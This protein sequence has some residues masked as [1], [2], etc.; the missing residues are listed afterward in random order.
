MIGCST[1][2]QVTTTSNNTH[3]P[4]TQ[5]TLWIQ[6]AAEYNALTSLVYRTASSKI[7]L[8]LA[9]SYW[10]AALEQEEPYFKLPPA[11]ILD[12]DETVLDNSPFQARMIRQGS[13]FNPEAWTKWV[14]EAQAE[15][16]LGA[17]EFTKYAANKGITVFYVTNRERRVEGATRTN[18]IR[19]GFPVADS[20]DVLLTKNEREAWTSDKTARREYVAKN[21]R[22]LMLLGDDLNDFVSTRNTGKQERDQLVESNLQKWGQQWF[23]LPNPTYGSWEQTLS[24]PEDSLSE[25]E[26]IRMIEAQ[27]NT[28]NNP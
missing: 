13:E 17:L 10:T 5:A 11:V 1:S 28:K 4:T 7:D 15:P 21:Y 23:I 20:V 24:S 26:K 2:Q 27:L 3:H 18:L 14:R 22:I 25:N 9:D 8:A 19:L 6:N 16:I 12:I